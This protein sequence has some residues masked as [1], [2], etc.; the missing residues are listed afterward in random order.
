MEQ[1]DQ[2]V[3]RKY[4]SREVHDRDAVVRVQILEEID[5]R[6]VEPVKMR[7]RQLDLA[8]KVA[9]SYYSYDSSS[10]SDKEEEDGEALDEAKLKEK[11]LQ[12]AR[13]CVIDK[14]EEITQKRLDNAL[15]LQEGEA[16][17][18]CKF[19]QKRRRYGGHYNLFNIR[20]SVASLLLPPRD[21]DGGKMS[22]KRYWTRTGGFGRSPRDSFIARNERR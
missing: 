15:L 11:E 7:M 18:K 12:S 20:N 8:K 2:N 13:K 3:S 19:R 22:T 14:E 21:A 16:Q 10:E 5:N 6:E 17:R 9:N 1:L 4:S